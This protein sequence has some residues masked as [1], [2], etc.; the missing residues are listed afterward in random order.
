MANPAKTVYGKLGLDFVGIAFG[1]LFYCLSFTPSLLPRGFVVQGI[2]SGLSL[3]AGYG[4]GVLLSVLY[5]SVTFKRRIKLSRLE[6]QI[7]IGVLILLAIIFMI[8]GQHWQD[9]I[10][11]LTEATGVPPVYSFNVA[12]IAIVVALLILWGARS[13]RKLGRFIGRK[14]AKFLPKKLAVYG[15]GILAA[16][17]IIFLINGVLF[18]SVFGF[19]NYSFGLANKGTPAGIHQPQN[20]IYSGSP[21]SAIDWNTL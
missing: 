1:L 7:I 14:L 5:H 10:R 18:K 6:K 13:A 12:I 21:S 8:A 20:S 17:L 19:I 9:Q 4:V 2:C 3:V 16:L 15:G 11:K